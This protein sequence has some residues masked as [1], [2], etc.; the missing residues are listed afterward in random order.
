[1]KGAEVGAGTAGRNWVIAGLRAARM[2]KNKERTSTCNGSGW[3]WVTT[4]LGTAVME[5]N[6]GRTVTGNGS[7]TLL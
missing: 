3:N 2:E 6:E 1:M 7:T 4:G 5:K